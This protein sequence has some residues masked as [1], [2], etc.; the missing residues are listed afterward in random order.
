MVAPD[1]VLSM[2]QKKSKLATLVEGDSKAPSSRATTLSS[3]GGLYTIPWIAPLYSWYLPLS[4][5]R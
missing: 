5:E 1:R 4:A 3:R 2:G